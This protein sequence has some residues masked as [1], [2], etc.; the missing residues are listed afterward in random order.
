VEG[1]DTLESAARREL[2]EETGFSADRL[3]FLAET[4]V[5]AGQSDE[6]ITFFRALG[7]RRVGEGGGD[8]SEEIDTHLVAL[9]SAED[10]LGARVR[11]GALVDA[12]VYA[13]LYFA[14]RDGDRD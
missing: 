7:L 3:E 5:S 9:E 2:L 11:A 12:K 1:D 8:G 6:V 13:G 10:W 14:R 4:P